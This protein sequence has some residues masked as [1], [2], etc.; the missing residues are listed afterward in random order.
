VRMPLFFLISGLFAARRLERPW[1]QVW[2]GRVAP[3]LYLFVLWTLVQTLVLQLTPGF[4]TAIAGSPGEL[5]VQLTITPG[6]LWYLL[7]LASYVVVARATRRAPHW[8]LGAALLLSAVAAAGW[9]ATPGNRYGLLTN[10]VWFLLGTRLPH[11]TRAVSRLTRPTPAVLVAAVG[12]F[13]VAAGAWQ[14]LGAD[15][16][17]GVRPVLGGLGIAAG[18]TVAATLA[19]AARIGSALAALGR[20]TLPVYVLHLPLVAVV[21]LGSVHLVGEGSSLARAVPVA[22]AYPV[23]VT[24]L[25]LAVCLGVHRAATRLGGGWLFEAPWQ[26]PAAPAPR[27]PAHAAT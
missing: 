19:R 18:L 21:H 23:L 13:A 27:T 20:R 5:L 1:A 2:T 4:D 8:T 14:V 15:E 25:V 12:A 11:L 16:W 3:L 22:V 7:A 10:L 9:V 17:F 26:R 6:N 24:T